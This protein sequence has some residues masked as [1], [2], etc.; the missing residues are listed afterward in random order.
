M[1]GLICTQS[2]G[3]QRG[4][5]DIDCRTAG[6]EASSSQLGSLSG[7]SYGVCRI[8]SGT[9]GLI[10]CFGNVCSGNAHA[11]GC[12]KDLLVQIAHGDLARVGDGADLG[13]GCLER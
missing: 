11:A 7:K 5:Q 6:S 2:I 9:D 1:D 3:I 4:G 8:L 10:G 13:K 12:I